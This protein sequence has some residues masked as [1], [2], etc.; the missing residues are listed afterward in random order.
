MIPERR[1][2]NMLLSLREK[3]NGSERQMDRDG[4][5]VVSRD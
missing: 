3:I 2:L 4:R 1:V 5:N